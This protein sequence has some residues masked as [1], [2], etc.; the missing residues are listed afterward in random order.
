MKLSF[1]PMSMLFATVLLILSTMSVVDAKLMPFIDP[2]AKVD[3]SVAA[4]GRSLSHA[5]E[6][7]KVLN[8]RRLEAAR[9]E[10]Q[11]KRQLKA[12]HPVLDTT[13]A[14]EANDDKAE[15]HRGLS[16][17]K[18]AMA[19]EG[20][21]GS[22]KYST[23]SVKSG[24]GSSSKGKGGK[25]KGGGKGSKS[26]K[27][28]TKRSG[29]S[30]KGGTTVV[31]T[32]PPTNPPTTSPTMMMMT[33]SPTMTIFSPPTNPPI[34]SSD[35]QGPISGDMAPVSEDTAPIISEDYQGPISGDAPMSE[36]YRASPISE[37]ASP[38]S[39]DT[40]PVSED[41]APIVSEDEGPIGGDMASSSDDGGAQGEDDTASDAS[42]TTTGD[43]EDEEPSDTGDS[44]GSDQG[45]TVPDDSDSNGDQGDI[46]D[47]G[48]AAEEEPVEQVEILTDMWDFAMVRTEAGSA[49]SPEEFNLTSVVAMT[50]VLYDFTAE[51]TINTDEAVGDFSATCVVVSR[52]H[53]VLCTYKIHLATAGTLGIGEFIARGHVRDHQNENFAL[54]TGTAFDWSQYTKGGSLVMQPNPTDPMIL[55]CSLTLR[56]PKDAAIN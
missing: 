18:S 44:Q 43:D 33:S 25:G 12:G 16:S 1:V 41:T 26:S 30:S 48:D 55:V 35:D 38:I 24:K 8:K 15:F 14:K 4:D 10:I 2:F 34:M 47:D 36:D 23:S 37:D 56:Y 31:E 29:M 19:L 53:D 7:K 3:S 52:E 49:D 28:S 20:A 5:Q 50:G 46:I 54:V 51:G 13:A 9:R 39:G 11:M 17:K 21:K 32:H 27:K 40:A 45:D 22:K 6:M 42:D